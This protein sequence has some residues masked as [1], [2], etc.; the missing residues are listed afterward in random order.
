MELLI[1]LSFLIPPG[2]FIWIEVLVYRN[3]L[4]AV[5]DNPI[6]ATLFWAVKSLLGAFPSGLLI[7]LIEF[8]VV[9]AF[10]RNYD[11]FSSFMSYQRGIT[12]FISLSLIL[13]VPLGLLWGVSRGAYRNYRKSMAENPDQSLD[14]IEKMSFKIFMAVLPVFLLISSSLFQGAGFEVFAYLL[15]G[16]APILFEQASK[17]FQ[18]WKTGS[19]AILV[20]IAFHGLMN[21]HY[22]KTPQP[23]A[24][25]KNSWKVRWTA[26]LAGIVVLI[27]LSGYAFIGAT[28]HTIKITQQPI[29]HYKSGRAYDSDTKSNLHNVYLACKAYWSDHGPDQSCNREIAS[30]TTYGYVQSSAVRIQATG[31]EEEFRALATNINSEKW[32][33]MDKLGTIQP[34]TPSKRKS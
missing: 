23:L 3:Y 30:G 26:G 7:M 5:E 2:L 9:M 32:F 24:Q 1:S 18:Y 13:G 16:W 27:F 25:H 34:L 17:L 14:H 6:R 20:L 29:V 31:G 28:R 22:S 8:P 4:K 10:L 33:W 19:M 11:E 21:W 12:A 15:L